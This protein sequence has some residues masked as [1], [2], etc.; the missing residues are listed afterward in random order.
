[1]I[2]RFALVLA[3]A[4][5]LQAAARRVVFSCERGNDLYRA[6]IAGG[7]SAPRYD[8]PAEAVGAAPRGS[9]VLLLAG[10]YPQALTP[11]TPEVFAEAKRKQLR[12]YVEFPSALPGLAV[13]APQSARWERGVVASDTFGSRLPRLRILALHDCRFVPVEAPVA[14][15][16]LARVAGF[17][18]AVYGL[19]EAAVHPL[20]FEHPGGNL[21][22]ATTKLSQF[23]TARYAPADAWQPIWDWILR[24]ALETDA[25]PRLRWT[26]AVQPSF[27]R[28]EDL[29]RGAAREAFRRGIGWFA[30]SR[31]L[32]HPALKTKFDEAAKYH[33]RVGPGPQP[34]WPVGD[35]SEGIL[36]GIS[37]SIAPDGSQPVRWYLRGDCIGEVSGAYAVSCLLD[38]NGEHCR[39]AARLNDFLY[40]RSLLTSGSRGDPT[41]PSYGL[42][43][44]SLPDYAGVYYGDDNARS[45]LGTMLAAA[46]L[47]SDRWDERLLRGLLANLRTTGRL[48]FRGYRLDEAPLQTQGWRRYF[49]G[50]RIHYAPHYESYLWA[51]YLW[52]FD[53][54]GYRLFLDRALNGIRMTMAAYPNEWRW[55]NGIQ[56]ERA[57]M[58]LPLAWLV[59]V[60][61]TVEHRAWL[62]RIASDLLSLQDAS[63][64]IREE[65]GS[66][67][68]GQYGPP[69]SNEEYGASEAPLI[70]TNGDRLTDVLYTSN[71][72][73]LGLH[74]A[75]AATGEHVF[76]DASAKLVNYLCRIQARS[77]SRPELD[78]AW[79]RAFDF[80]RWD[81]WASNA[82]AGWGAWS[83]E[84][85][86]TQAWITT[87]LGMREMRT[88]LWQVTS[89]SAIGKQ[90]PAMIPAMI[91]DSAFAAQ[92]Q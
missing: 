71:F 87:V 43:G 46:A 23:V 45:F 25:P 31:L 54:T 10:G 50:D 66:D 44:W 90:A 77:A 42:L 33:D 36:E 89:K 12:L 70:Q 13:G 40:F 47:K 92:E 81:Y 48:G 64:A 68:R 1:M 16:V 37:S 74:E 85:G 91:P 57:R 34:G 22:V 63:G 72:A 30:K 62:R 26:P 2:R 69:K 86:W 7:L 82:D 59:R 53:K 73:F 41:S 38:G 88:S 75:G 52:A 28:D 9:S 76:A 84:T 4:A 14:H 67:G 35:G 65:I 80:G 55:T 3:L 21:I 5:A 15:M 78:G 58:L 24:W 18:S 61:D 60:E 49:S 32:V 51:A 19:P 79:F 27:T 56:Q 11:L 83:V 6:V 39:I 8:S 17:D 29:P 20:L